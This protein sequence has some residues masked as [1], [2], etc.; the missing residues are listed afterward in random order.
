M[1]ALAATL[2]GWSQAQ[3][4]WIER[5]GEPARKYFSKT[6]GPP[7]QTMTFVSALGAFTLIAFVA[8]LVHLPCDMVVSGGEGLTDWLVRPFWPFSSAGYVFPLIPWGDVGPTVILMIGAIVL[9]KRP[10][11]ASAIAAI[12]LVTLVLYLVVRGWSR[13]LV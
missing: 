13:G 9:A 5:I 2:L 6:G 10:V 8:Q 1:I 4:R 11:K 7:R 3:F 12:T